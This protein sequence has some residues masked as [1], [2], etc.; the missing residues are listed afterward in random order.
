ML[1]TKYHPKTLDEIINEKNRLYLNEML[2]WCTS[3]TFDDNIK[4]RGRPKKSDTFERISTKKPGT[5]FVGDVGVG[6]TSMLDVFQR[7]I[8]PDMDTVT[9]ECSKISRKNFDEF[10]KQ[11]VSYKNVLNFNKKKLIRFDELESLSE[12]DNLQLS[13]IIKCI[14][15]SKM[16]FIGS[17]HN[18]Y[19]NRILEYKRFINIYIINKPTICE[20][21][22]FIENVCKAEGYN[23]TEA[24]K[25]PYDYDLRSYLT[26]IEFSWNS[27]KDVFI[28][29]NNEAISKL[30]HG[31][32]IGYSVN[33]MNIVLHENY[34]YAK[35]A[36]K[37]IRYLCDGDGFANES[38]ENIYI[39]YIASCNYRVITA[40]DENMALRP[41]SLWTKTSNAN[42][43]RKLNK[44]RIRDRVLDN[45]FDALTT[46]TIERLH[47]MENDI[48]IKK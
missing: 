44:E 29:D 40:L 26:S 27:H 43:K 1:Y 48:G 45:T 39:E 23:F 15:T 7:L 41:A 18:K 9:F 31:K 36:C 16:P 11:T 6:K 30:R 33:N 22:T 34:P 13:D 25:V 2:S 46:S 20:R 17:I 5:I 14:K 10:F 32:C 8:K 12:G 4:H 42:L 28:N 47:A 21:E 3:V 19:L 38:I 35:D 24:M 37:S